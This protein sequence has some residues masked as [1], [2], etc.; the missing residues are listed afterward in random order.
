MTS[1]IHNDVRKF[2]LKFW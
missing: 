1:Q 2:F